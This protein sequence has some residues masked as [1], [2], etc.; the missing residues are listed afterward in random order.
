MTSEVA[1]FESSSK[2][3]V[4]AHRHAEPVA[5]DGRDE[6]PPGHQAVMRK[7]PFG[8]TMDRLV[9]VELNRHDALSSEK[10][11]MPA[12]VDA[13]PAASITFPSTVDDARRHGDRDAVVRLELACAVRDVFVA[14]RD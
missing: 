14:H 1:T 3:A 8:S 5:R 6:I 9:R 7:C 10:R 2:R 4:A 11:M 13:A 12:S